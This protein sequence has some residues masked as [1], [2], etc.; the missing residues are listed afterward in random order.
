MFDPPPA[1]ADL[2]GL[3]RLSL[4]SHSRRSFLRFVIPHG[5]PTST[6]LRPLAPRA[7]PRFLATTD[8]LTA[9][10]AALRILRDH[11]LRLTPSRV[12]CLTPSTFLPFC[13]QPPQPPGSGFLTLPFNRTG[14]RAFARFWTSPF[15]RRLVG[16]CGRI[17][18]AGA[19]DRQFVSRCSPRRLTTTQLRSASGRRTFARDGL[20]P[21]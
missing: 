7:L 17:R 9:A 15:L 5:L 13:P 6:F 11:E 1:V 21:S 19:A 20:A 16:S 10:R 4:P 12:P 14:F 2:S 8:A 3:F 18:F